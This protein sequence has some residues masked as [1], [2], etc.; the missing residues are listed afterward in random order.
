MI[1]YLEG[2]KLTFALVINN[3]SDTSFVTCDSCFEGAFVSIG[4]TIGTANWIKHHWAG[5]HART[6]SRMG[7]FQIGV[8]ALSF[9]VEDAWITYNRVFKSSSHIMKTNL[10]FWISLNE[11]KLKSFQ[12]TRFGVRN[13]F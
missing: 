9:S 7:N 8:V 13:T 3:S 10:I 11:P 6:F 12:T 5:D 2:F 1:S 4:D